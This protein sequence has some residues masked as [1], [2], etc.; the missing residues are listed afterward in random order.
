MCTQPCPVVTK[1]K[2]KYA[3][4][5][6]G[7][8]LGPNERPSQVHFIDRRKVEGEVD[9]PPD[10][11]VE[12][13]E[14]GYQ[15]AS[16]SQAAAGGGMVSQKLRI[17][18]S[19]ILGMLRTVREPIVDYQENRGVSRTEQISFV[20]LVTS[21]CTHAYTAAIT[22][23]VMLWNLAP[24]L[25]GFV[26]FARFLLDRLIDIV[27]TEDPK[28]KIVKSIVFLVEIIIVLFIIFLIM[29]LI[30]MPVYVLAARIASKVWGMISW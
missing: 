13:N 21:L 28:D 5:Q 16:E 12:L 30:F 3:R 14:Q 20:T 24:L 2:E 7:L 23:L 22:I 9:Q 29:G 26:Y 4:K 15:V 17:S 10:G 1:C 19:Q 11:L 8:L 25:D 6:A 27:E 18:Q